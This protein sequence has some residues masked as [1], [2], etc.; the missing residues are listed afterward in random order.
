MLTILIT[1]EMRKENFRLKRKA[2]SGIVLTRARDFSNLQQDATLKLYKEA[3]S[4]GSHIEVKI[5]RLTIGSEE[6]C[7]WE[8]DPISCETALKWTLT[9]N[10]PES[11]DQ[12]VDF[13]YIKEEYD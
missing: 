3:K 13:N 4:T 9:S 1:Y 8:T 10:P 2:V 11:G 12:T 5:K 6:R 7:A